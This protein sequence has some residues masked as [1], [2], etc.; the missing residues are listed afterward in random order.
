MPA[1]LERRWAEFVAA[2]GRLT[3]NRNVGYKKKP[4]IYTFSGAPTDEF[5]ALQDSL[6]TAAAVAITR[7]GYLVYA[8]DGDDD[9]SR[10]R[11]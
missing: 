10:M 4:P 3:E 8:V 7:G 5:D 11:H 2:R 9:A 1:A 6:A